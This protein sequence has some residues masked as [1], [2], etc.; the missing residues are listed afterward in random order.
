MSTMETSKLT[1][2]NITIDYDYDCVPPAGDEGGCHKIPAKGRESGKLIDSARVL[3]VVC[4]HF[5]G[6]CHSC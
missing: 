2:Q 1:R 6:S 4:C 5:S 3:A